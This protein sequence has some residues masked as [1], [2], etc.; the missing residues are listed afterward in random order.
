MKIEFPLSHGIK[1]VISSETYLGTGYP[2][3]RIQKGLV[4]FCDGQSLVEEAVGFGVPIL[5][6]GLQTIFPGQIELFPHEG[7]SSN[8]VS[9]RYNMNLVE[10]IAKSDGDTLNNRQV[11]A[12]KNL[13]AGLIRSLP[14]LRGLLT[15]TS[16]LLRSALDWQTTYEPI[17][18][19]THVT[20]TYSIDAALGRVLVELIG[21]EYIPNS[22]SEIIVMNEQG[23]HQFDQ[24]QDSDGISEIGNKI[25]CWDQVKAASASFSSS[26]LQVAFSLP[27]KSG[28][29]L[30]RGRELIGKRLAWSG[31]G[32]SFPPSL[33]HFSYEITIKR[34]P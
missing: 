1:L 27:Q 15:R 9:A 7:R 3:A 8:R 21:Q 14:F 29:K 30:Y 23:A 16:S 31:F 5:K 25:G 33:N 28:A 10:K 2:T 22:V 18:F 13:L 20:L 12:G 24:Y 26:E 19:F 11:Y 34:L 32:Y 6:R 4:L 17:N